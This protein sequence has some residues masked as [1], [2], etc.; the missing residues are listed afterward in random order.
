MSACAS[1]GGPSEE[2]ARYCSRCGAPLA[3]A[4]PTAAVARKVVTVLFSD[5][6][7][8]T[9]LGERLDPESLHQ[10]M[11]R[12]FDGADEAIRRHGG[13]VEKHIGDAVMAVFGVPVAHEDD[14][15]RAARAA[16]DMREGLDGLNHELG[17][18]WDVRLTV[19]TGI[20]TG[21]VVVADDPQGQPS[22]LGDAVNVAQRL[23]AAAEPGQVLV[24][25]PTARLVRGAARLDR[26]VELAVKGKAVP[27][28][29]RRL[30]AV[31]SAARMSSGCSAGP[32]T[33]P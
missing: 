22:I 33:T 27:V 19:R 16:L 13:T 1:C 4:D 15:L 25:E 18:R 28:R 32:S 12:W 17:R 6:R 31:E 30:V 21:E 26:V 14:A 5:V 23:E 2:G 9:A 8:F 29:A 20:N 24:G 7:G 3:G 10:V 11:R